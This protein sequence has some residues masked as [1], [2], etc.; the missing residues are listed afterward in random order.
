MS[1]EQIKNLCIQLMKA[2]TENEIVKLLKDYGYWDNQFCW[3]WYGDK[4]NN[5]K[6]AGNQAAE[7]E[8]ALVEKITNSR[9]ARLMNE[10]LLR[11]IDPEGPDA[12]KNLESAVAMFFDNNSKSETA[13]LIREWTDS[14]RTD[15]A[16]GITLA[17]TGNKPGQGDPSLT[18]SDCG[19]GQTPLKMPKTILSL[20]ENIKMRIPFVHGKFNMGGTAVLRFC[21]YHNLQLI[22]SKRNTKLIVNK[23]N[24]SN[25]NWGFTIVR[26]NYPK[27][28]FDT[29]VTSEDKTRSSIYT[30]LAPIDAEK[31]PGHGEILNFYSPTLPIF[32]HGNSP[33]VKESEWGT[34]I[35]LYEFKT[36][37]RTHMFRTDGLLS[38]LDLLLP[39][40]G[41]PVRLHECRDYRGHEGSFE[42][43]LTGLRVRLDEGRDNLEWIPDSTEININRNKFKV[44]IYAFK[45]G[46]GKIYRPLYIPGC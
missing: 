1:D 11:E 2:D 45:E 10:C 4:E 5:Y 20:G 42:T 14:K 39:K 31:N 33:Y 44:T 19:E 17:I 21:G 28:N 38:I 22:I 16:R 9:D 13:G 15:I 30:Y 43:T 41:L 7:A 23:L 6:D 35:K 12:P 3:R 32:P 25:N 26:R 40:I 36:K 8:A 27:G 46:K 37:Y 29:A 18:I 34:L 24:E